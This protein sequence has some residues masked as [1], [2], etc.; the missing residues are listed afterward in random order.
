MAG[1]ARRKMARAVTLARGQVVSDALLSK[2]AGRL[3][4]AK[5]RA[6]HVRDIPELVREAAARDHSPKGIARGA[7]LHSSKIIYLP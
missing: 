1:L 5:D 6:R 3:T 4:E 7:C 2:G